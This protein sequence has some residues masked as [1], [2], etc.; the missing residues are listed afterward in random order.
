MQADDGGSVGDAAQGI[1]VDAQSTGDEREASS[2]DG[3]PTF[4]GLA[5]DGALC[6]TDNGSTCGVA[7]GAGASAESSN[8]ALGLL[9]PASLCLAFGLRRGARR[10]AR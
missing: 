3:G 10:P 1:D 5:C 6:A 7:G 9:F 2:E 4:L 8:G